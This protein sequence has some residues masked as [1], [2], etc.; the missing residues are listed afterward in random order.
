MSYNRGYLLGRLF[1]SLARLGALEEPARL[2]QSASTTPPQ[3]FP[4][5]LAAAI[6]AGKEEALYP[7]M[8]LLP[9]DAF[10]GPL[11][12]RELGAFAI[13]YAHERAGYQG[14]LLEEEGDDLEQELTERYE[15]RLE[16]QLKEWIKTNGGGAFIRSVL[17]AERAKQSQTATS[18][19]T[20]ES[21]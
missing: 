17:R 2:Y 18:E 9:Q 19:L 5:A 6:E 21:E 7:L 16:S 1:A 14:P 8:K 12:R 20:R 15:F 10:E 4:Q 3:V 13:G 11:N